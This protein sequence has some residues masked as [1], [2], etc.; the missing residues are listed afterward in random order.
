MRTDSHRWTRRQM[1]LWRRTYMMQKTVNIQLNNNHY[2]NVTILIWFNKRQCVLFL[3][4]LMGVHD[5]FVLM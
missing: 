4:G 3:F 2:G 5:Y 1:L